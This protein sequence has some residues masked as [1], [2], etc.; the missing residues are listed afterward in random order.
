[1]AQLQQ[2]KFSLLFVATLFLGS[3]GQYSRFADRT[4]GLTTVRFGTGPTNGPAALTLT[5]G[6]M[7]YA[8]GEGGLPQR[9]IKLVDAGNASGS[10]SLTLPN[11]SY[12]FYALG[13]SAANL[14]GTVACGSANAGEPLA[15][16]GTART[17]ELNLTHT[18]CQDSPFTSSALFYLPG[19]GFRP[20]QLVSCDSVAGNA[21]VEAFTA[22]STCTGGGLEG[23]ITNYKSLKIHLAG[24]ST[25]AGAPSAAQL[26]TADAISS[27]CIRGSGFP[28][29][30]NS[31]A[32]AGTGAQGVGTI[33]TS[34][35]FFTDQSGGIFRSTDGGAS[36]TNPI[37]GIDARQ[38]K[39]SGARIIISTSADVRISNDSGDNFTVAISAFPYWGVDV[40]GD[41]MAAGLNNATGD[42]RL[43]TDGGA[44]FAAAEN[45]GHSVNIQSIFIEPES[46]GFRTY[47]AGG[48]WVARRSVGGTWGDILDI[49][50]GQTVKFVSVIDG[51]IYVGGTNGIWI[52]TNDGASFTQ[53]CDTGCTN[54]NAIHSNNVISILKIGQTVYLGTGDGLALSLDGGNTWS[55]TNVI[56]GTN[57]TTTPGS[58]YQMATNGED[59]FLAVN[60]AT[61]SARRL[62]KAGNGGA[63]PGTAVHQIPASAVGTPHTFPIIVETFDDAVCSSSSGTYRLN[64]GAA[65][66]SAATHN[67]V[68]RTNGANVR[69]FLRRP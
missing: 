28:I 37:T 60:A 15:L 49:G 2:K 56:N 25:A 47:A 31:N 3:C 42:I 35:V 32:I 20:L 64:T 59:I 36:W 48:Q 18:N 57:L 55:N 61:T 13:Y 26:Q 53:Y 10:R 69:L 34:R 43:S 40:A 12:R 52:S 50:G 21:T 54:V 27:D 17:V 41:V 38:I 8:I 58:I 1:M 65:N 67:A 16:N 24:F 29:A 19:S 44:N 45:F 68:Y 11:G 22:T 62:V 5:G 51:K 63:F 46:G 30:T 14:Q 39:T 6:V 9:T 33:G 66:A 23:E 4:D 7:I